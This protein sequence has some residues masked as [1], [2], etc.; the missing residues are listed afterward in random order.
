M[1]RVARNRGLTSEVTS[2]VHGEDARRGDELVV[3][4]GGIRLQR[5]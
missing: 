1:R 5:R 4:A 3:T 2:R